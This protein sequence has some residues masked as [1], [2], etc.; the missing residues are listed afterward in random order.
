LSKYVIFSLPAKSEILQ[1]AQN[2]IIS[3]EIE[4]FIVNKPNIGWWKIFRIEKYYHIGLAWSSGF[5]IECRMANLV[6]TF[7]Y[8]LKWR[9]VLKHYLHL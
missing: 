1:I 9:N 3:A 4:Q 6:N 5:K 2:H 8:I 7:L